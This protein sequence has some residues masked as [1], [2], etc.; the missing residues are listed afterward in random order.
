MIAKFL[1]LFLLLLPLSQS[2]TIGIFPTNETIH[3]KPLYNYKIHFYLFN[4][5]M[6][7][8]NVSLSIK[9]QSDGKDYP[10][11]SIFPQSINLPAKTDML[12][13]KIITVSIRNPLFFK[14]G[15]IPMPAFGEKDIKCR[16]YAKV[17]GMTNLIVTSRIS[18][19]IVGLNVL[20]LLS[21]LFLLTVFVSIKILS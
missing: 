13:P 12:N 9:C 21:F 17:E 11:A 7:D 4:P 3:I 6:N 14:D 5:S 2:T 1:I 16:L 20:K 18:G 10:F 15:I 8:Q 19:K